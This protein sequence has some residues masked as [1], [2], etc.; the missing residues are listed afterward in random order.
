[1]IKKSSHLCSKEYYKELKAK[2]DAH[3]SKENDQ[4][5]LKHAVSL[6]DAWHTIF[7][8]IFSQAVKYTI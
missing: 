3:I 8:E 2:S 4:N 7:R 6:L 1:M 5:D